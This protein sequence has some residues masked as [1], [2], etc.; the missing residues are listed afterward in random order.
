[1]QEYGTC[2][3]ISGRCGLFGGFYLGL[4]D[5]SNFANS[6]NHLWMDLK[7]VAK[8]LTTCGKIMVKFWKIVV[9]LVVCK[10]LTFLEN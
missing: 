7:S 9:D 10:F 1:M 4:V 8:S 6:P 3:A 2:L 5:G